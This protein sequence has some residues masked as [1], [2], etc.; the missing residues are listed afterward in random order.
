MRTPMSNRRTPAA[1]NP[2]RSRTAP[3]RVAP[4][5]LT[6]LAIICYTVAPYIGRVQAAVV[7][8][9]PVFSA[10]RGFFSSPFNLTLTSPSGGSIRYTLDGSTPSPTK[11]TVYSSPISITTTKAVRAIAYSASDTSLVATNTYIFLA[12]VRN[13]SATPPAGWPSKFAADDSDGY[14]PA[15]YE[16][17]PEVVNH[18]FYSADF[19]ASLQSLPSISINTDLPNLWDPSYGIYYNPNAKEP[20]DTDP[21]GTKW[22]R[23]IS[24]E[25]INPDGSAGFGELGGM[26]ING[27]ASRRPNRQPKKSFR[28]YFKASYGTPKLDFQLFDQDDPVTKFDRIVLRNG[29]NRTWSYW[30]RDQRREADYVNDEWARRAWLRMGNLAPHGNYVHVY[31]NGLYWGL[32]NVTERIDEKF[33]QSYLGLAE[34]DY[35][36][37]EADEDVGDIAVASAG[38]ID[39]WNQVLA[40]VNSSAPNPI[41]NA[42]YQ[43]IAAKVDVTNLADYFVHVHYIGKTD[44]PEHNYTIYRQR[45]GS[46]TRFKFMPWDNDSGL[47]NVTQNMTNYYDDDG[48]ADAPVHVFLRLTTNPEFRQVL[49]DRLYRNVV[50]PNGILTPTSCASIYTDLAAIVDQAVIGESARWGDYMRDLYPTTNIPA[51]PKAFPAYLHSRNLPDAY[52]DPAGAVADNV[53]KTWLDVK[54]EKLA[55]YCPQRSTN[56]VGQYAAEHHEFLGKTVEPPVPTAIPQ[57]DSPSWYP[58][59]VK[60]PFFSQAGGAVPTGYSLAINNSPNSNAGD[61]YYTT[62][63]TDPRAFGG[64]V[65]AGAL[66]GADSASVPITTVTKVRARVLSA[67]VWSPLRESTFYPPQQFENL[68]INEIHYNPVAPAT[69]AGMASSDYEFVELYNKGTTPLRLDDVSFSRGFSYTFPANTTLGA[70]QYLVLASEPANYQARYGVAPFGDFRGNLSNVGEAIEIKDAVGNVIDM[71]DYG[72]IAPWPTA[73]NG[74]GGSLALGSPSWDNSAPTNWLVGPTN[75]TPGMVN[76]ADPGPPPPTSTPTTTPVPSTTPVPGQQ[77]LYLPSVNMP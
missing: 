42:L 2:R 37:I 54:T 21:K 76:G 34:T 25:M 14:Y 17:D 67:G 40:L 20:Y 12:N 63:G 41:D 32:Y 9:P 27:Q 38:T 15:D 66:S 6:I 1:D 33:L 30:D 22:E 51:G 68:I 46:D 44:W 29:G 50:D 70:G 36:I 59:T 56:V 26:R 75:G 58:T 73:P 28:V 5:A 52:T 77:R 71:V 8:T 43:Q 47:N 16:M 18:P 4:L 55:N 62:N 74:G 11:G 24:I 3:V 13:Q 10:Q 69:P 64:A 60:V 19:D 7:L 65:A 48:P 49:A 53:Q 45:V 72:I 31:L 39:A 35:D 61:I 23:P 57:Y